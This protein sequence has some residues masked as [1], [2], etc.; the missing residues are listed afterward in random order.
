MFL[1]RSIVA[2]PIKRGKLKNH[3]LI[4]PPYI[5]YV[6]RDKENVPKPVALEG[7]L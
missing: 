3:E 7:N 4:D 5:L 1:N 6:D 2:L